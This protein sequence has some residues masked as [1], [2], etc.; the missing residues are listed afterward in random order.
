MMA[1]PVRMLPFVC[2]RSCTPVPASCRH[3]RIETLPEREFARFRKANEQLQA[4]GSELF[5]TSAG[6]GQFK[7]TGRPGRIT[8]NSPIGP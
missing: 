3:H 7:L 4:S 6:L 5:T 8:R 1:A 2:S